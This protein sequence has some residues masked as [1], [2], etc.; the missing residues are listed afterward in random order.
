[1]PLFGTSTQTFYLEPFGTSRLIV[2]DGDDGV[3]VIA[4]EPAADSTL[5]SLLP[6]ANRVVSSVRFR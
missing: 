4:I 2:I 1:V 3:L 6:E 5:E